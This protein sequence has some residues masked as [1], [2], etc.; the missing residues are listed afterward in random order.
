MDFGMETSIFLAYTA[1]MLMLYF[2]GRLFFVPIKLLLKL[3]F[4]SILGGAALIVIRFTGD[5]IGFNLPVNP[6]N[7]VI[8]GV[9]GAPGVL[10]LLLY[11]NI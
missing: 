3:M 7:A 8:A 9:A 5:I 6:V 2:L 11:F 10:G 4:S 1:G